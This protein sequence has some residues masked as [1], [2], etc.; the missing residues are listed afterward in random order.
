V[1]AILATF[2]ALAAA[3]GAQ[4]AGKDAKP[5]EPLVRCIPCQNQGRVPC[6][7]H[8]KG[9]MHFEDGVQYCSVLAGCATCGGTGWLDCGDCE[10][11]KWA[12]AL[13]RKR[14][15]IASLEAPALAK[16][17]QEMG[18][19]LRMV[20]TEHFVLVWEIDQLKIDK[21]QVEH[22]ELMHVYADRL[23][24]LYS[25]YLAAFQASPRDFR[26]RTQVLVWWLPKDQEEA[27]NRFAGN[28]SPRGIKLLGSTS[29]YSCCGNKQFSKDDETLH[30]SIVHNV[31]HLLL[32][33]Q[34]PSL[35]L[36]N[37]KHGWVDEGVAHWFE[38]KLFGVCDNY[39]YEEQNTNVDFK[40]GRWKPVVRKM[41]AMDDVPPV[42]EVMSK[43][44]DGLSLPMHAVAFSYVDYLLAT[45]GAKFNALCR[46]LRQRVE[47]RDAF[48]KVYG[49]GL[50]EFEQKWKAWVL[51][52]YPVR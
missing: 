12:E 34:N 27:S 50:I 38:E 35:W 25:E 46:N 2:A 6:D 49:F 1:T 47:G 29:V 23:E 22:H 7:E 16:Y 33:H 19:K 15:R 13:G 5:D 8:D 3:L 45:D 41:V 31:S 10:N 48:Q 20:S 39:C 32:A 44:T 40:G 18:R 28:Q 17:D 14:T 37:L 51:A 52:T 36:G 24:K 26:E 43:N 30:R 11:P 4:G 42:G 9:E 21:R